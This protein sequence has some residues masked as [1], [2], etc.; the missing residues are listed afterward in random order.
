MKASRTSIL[1][2]AAVLLAV[3][4]ASAQNSSMGIKAGITLASADV[5][6]LDGT[7]DTENRTGWGVGAFL[8]L[9]R[10]LISIQ[11]EINFVELGFEAAGLPGA[12]EVKLRY[13]APTVLLKLGLPLAVVRPSVFAGAGIGIELSCSIDDTDCEQAPVAFETG[14]SDATGIF[15]ADLDIILGASI[16]RA[17]VRYAIGFSDIHEAS[18]V[19]TEIKNRAWQVSVGIGTRF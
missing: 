18:D 9:G 4:Q 5:K 11:P 14:T 7:F 3:S 2:L 8:T 19:W 17:D 1:A 12:P 10:G 16:L 6:D 15:G 13:V